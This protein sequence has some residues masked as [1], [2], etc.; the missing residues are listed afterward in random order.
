MSAFEKSQKE[1]V[2]IFDIGERAYQTKTK[3]WKNYYEE[4]GEN[5]L[6]DIKLKVNVKIGNI[7]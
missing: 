5:Y 3:K 2:D 6:R 1:G 7:N 4:V